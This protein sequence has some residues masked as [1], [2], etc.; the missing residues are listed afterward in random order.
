ASASDIAR[1]LGLAH[2]PVLITADGLSQ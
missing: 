1:R 2:Y